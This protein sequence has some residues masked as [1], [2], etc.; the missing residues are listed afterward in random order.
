MVSSEVL[1]KIHQPTLVIHS[2]EDNS[3]PFSHAEWS[4]KNIPKAELCESGFTGHFFW[5]GPDFERISQQTIKFLGK[6][7]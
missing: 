3:V 7:P 2:R 6:N 5:I 1:G 4:L